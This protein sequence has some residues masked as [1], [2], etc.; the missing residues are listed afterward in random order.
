[1]AIKK[2][3]KTEGQS[4]QTNKFID[5]LNE[6]VDWA[7]AFEPKILTKQEE[8]RKADEELIKVIEQCLEDEYAGVELEEVFTTWK[9]LRAGETK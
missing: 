7:N 3:E 4:L 8:L 1:M 6:I 2:L 5:K 9:S